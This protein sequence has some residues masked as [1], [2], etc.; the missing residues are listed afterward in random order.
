[1][2]TEKCNLKNLLKTK[3]HSGFRWT[4]TGSIIYEVL[5]AIHYFCLFKYLDIVSYGF[6]GSLFAVIYLTSKFADIGNSYSISPFYNYIITSKQTF[7]KTLLNYYLLPQLPI[8]LITTTIATY[9]YI[10]YFFNGN[11]QIFWALLPSL[12]I[13]ETIRSFLRYFLHITFKNRTIVLIELTIFMIYLSS[14]WTLFLGF[15]FNLSPNLIFIPHLFDSGI[16]VSIFIFLML[17]Q[18]NTLPQEK[19]KF[20]KGLK[21][22]IFHSRIFNYFLRIS[23]DLF[24]SNFITPFFA[25]KFGLKQAG[26]FFLAGIV[27]TSLQSIVKAAISYPGNALLAS[28]KNCPNKLKDEAFGILSTKLMV[29]ISPLIIFTAINHKTLVRLSN[30]KD[31]TSTTLS[32]L[33]LYLLITFIEFFFT[34]YEQFFILEEAGQRLFLFKLFEFMLLYAALTTNANA[35]PSIIL[36]SLIAIKVISLLIIAI[37]AF[38][39]WKIQPTFKISLNY[40]ITC[41]GISLVAYYFLSARILI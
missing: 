1:M 8:L 4:L 19:T 31:I 38:Y 10:K 32:F 12:I 25:A 6:I 22:R 17:K 39:H 33:I 11:Q 34:L 36:T 16:T 9:F 14:I 13:L 27:V 30:L 29:I 21:K 35:S 3:Y 40:F 5:K 26:I 15:N 7:K 37:T 28:I 18:Y 23:K 41:I 20:P 24:T 2:T